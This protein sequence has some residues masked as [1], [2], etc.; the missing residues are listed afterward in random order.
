M[1]S[2]WKIFYKLWKG[3]HHHFYKDD[4]KNYFAGTYNKSLIYDKP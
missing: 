1:P 2:F 3:F 4:K